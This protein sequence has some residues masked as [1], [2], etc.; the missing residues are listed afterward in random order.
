ME[1][2]TMPP[3]YSS[4]CLAQMLRLTW[5]PGEPFPRPWQAA[6]PLWTR[7]L[8]DFFFFIAFYEFVSLLTTSPLCLVNLYL[9]S[10]NHHWDSPHVSPPLE[11][12]L[13][14]SGPDCFSRTV[15][16]SFSTTSISLILTFT[17]T[18]FYQCLFPC[19]SFP[20][21]QIG[22]LLPKQISPFPLGHS[23]RLLLPRFLCS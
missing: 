6:S 19:L 11:I 21:W 16:C 8:Q 15:W 5:G 1:Q 12:L 10:Q 23:V 7:S 9:F 13:D 20:L 14:H 18:L 4:S 22:S 3:L 17:Y 2:T